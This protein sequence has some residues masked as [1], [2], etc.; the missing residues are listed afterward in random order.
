MRY[1]KS[2]GN[3]WISCGKRERVLPREAGLMVW[4]VSKYLR[5]KG[6]PSRGPSRPE[7]DS[8]DG[9]GLGAG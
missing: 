1:L 4:M 5:V 3:V 2:R 9:A 8:G 7:A 6:Q